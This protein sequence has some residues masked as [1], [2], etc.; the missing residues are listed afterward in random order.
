MLASEVIAF[1]D[2]A[3]KHHGDMDVVIQINPPD[4]VSKV[5]GFWTRE[6]AETG[7]RTLIICHRAAA[8]QVKV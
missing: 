8:A 4:A 7:I 5:T 1:I 2:D 3:I 6:D